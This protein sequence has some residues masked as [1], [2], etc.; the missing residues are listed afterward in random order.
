MSRKITQHKAVLEYLK[1]YGHLYGDHDHTR[2]DSEQSRLL[3]TIYGRN[4]QASSVTG[5][6]AK[7]HAAG[8]IAADPKKEDSK[9]LLVPDYQKRLEEFEARERAKNDKTMIKMGRIVSGGKEDTAELDKLGEIDKPFG[10]AKEKREAGCR[11]R[12][13]EFCKG[14]ALFTG[15]TEW[16][17]RQA[18]HS[19]EVKAI[20]RIADNTKWNLQLL[21]NDI[22]AMRDAGVAEIHCTETGLE[23]KINSK[24]PKYAPFNGLKEEILDPYDRREVQKRIIIGN[25]ARGIKQDI[26]AWF[27]KWQQDEG[28]I[29]TVKRPAIEPAMLF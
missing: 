28:I 13:E 27:V 22:H 10:N 25:M 6:I 14:R 26:P 16:S 23:L 24:D 5:C 4:V 21:R 8:V 19:I 1:Q 3:E 7:L 17:G 18:S 9:W 15:E 29:D 20:P 2:D 11:R 12:A